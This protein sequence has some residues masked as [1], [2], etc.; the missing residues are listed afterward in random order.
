MS[1]GFD[2][3]FDKEAVKKLDKGTLVK[4]KVGSRLL[5]GRVLRYITSENKYLINFK[6]QG[7][8]PVSESDIIFI[9][10]NGE[11]KEAVDVVMIPFRFFDPDID[12]EPDEEYEEL[13]IEY[14]IFRFDVIGETIHGNKVIECRGGFDVLVESEEYPEYYEVYTRFNDWEGLW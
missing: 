4:V 1:I 5:D 2:K 10:R 7:L 8:K 3:L 6:G 9:I 11:P 14:Y 12:E 13:P